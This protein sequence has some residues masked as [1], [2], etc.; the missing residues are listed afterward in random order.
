MGKMGLMILPR[1]VVFLLFFV[2]A[3]GAF[4]QSEDETFES[5]FKLDPLVPPVENAGNDGI[6]GGT[7]SQP[8]EPLLLSELEDLNGGD[9]P[10]APVDPNG[11]YPSEA[12]GNRERVEEPEIPVES[13]N[14]QVEVVQPEDLQP[15]LSLPRGTISGNDGLKSG[16]YVAYGEQLVPYHWA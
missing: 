3:K 16:K 5:A 1:A 4:A 7:S 10:V 2:A 11:E 15:E 8:L 12:D 13:S 14:G 6:A 9:P